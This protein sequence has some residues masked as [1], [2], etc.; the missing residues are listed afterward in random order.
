M[1]NIIVIAISA[2]MFALLLA[3]RRW[4]SFRSW[5]EE[6]KYSM[7]CQERRFDDQRD[8]AGN[9]PVADGGHA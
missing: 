9:D 6:P 4:P 1:I 2:I 7:L 5:M 8:G 3:W